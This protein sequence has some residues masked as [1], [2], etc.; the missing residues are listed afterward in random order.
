MKKVLSVLVIL[1]F[2][3]VLNTTDSNIRAF[4][5]NETEYDNI[6]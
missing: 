5:Y 1:A 2:F 3:L 6:S 4:N